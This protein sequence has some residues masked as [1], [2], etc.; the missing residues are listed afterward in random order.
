MVEWQSR[1]I[2]LVDERSAMAVGNNVADLAV[3]GR[4][5]HDQIDGDRLSNSPHSQVKRANIAG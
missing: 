5:S 4:A 3:S 1:A 2:P